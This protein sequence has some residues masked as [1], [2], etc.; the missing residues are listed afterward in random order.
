MKTASEAVTENGLSTLSTKQRNKRTRFSFRRTPALFFLLLAANAFAQDGVIV[1]NLADLAQGA[2]SSEHSI[3]LPFE[4]WHWQA[5]SIDGGQP[6]WINFSQFPCLELLQA[7]TNVSTDTEFHGVPLVSAQL[8]KNV[9]TGEVLFQSECSSDVLAT[10]AAP[11]GYQPGV[12][13]KDRGVWEMWQQ[14]T[15][16]PDCWGVP[17]GGFLPPTVKLNV[18]LADLNDYAAYDSNLEVEAEAEALL[19]EQT[20]TTS[21]MSTAIAEADGGGG[22]VFDGRQ[23]SVYDHKYS[24]PIR[25]CEHRPRHKP[26]DDNRMA[27]LHRS[28]LRAVLNGQPQ[29]E[30]T[31]DWA[32]S[33]VG[34]RG[35]DQLDG[36][37]YHQRQSPVLQ[38]CANVAPGADFDG[39][40]IPNG[41]ELQYGINPLDPADAAGIAT[42][43]GLTYWD[44]SLMGDDFQGDTCVG[45]V[46]CGCNFHQR[47]KWYGGKP[48]STFAARH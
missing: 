17:D 40:G 6:W 32:D 16:C 20:S 15:N 13:S 38:G 46:I 10:V 27:K 33:D 4:P 22:N 43:D 30:H 2:F 7:C 5:Y 31:L 34:C 11:S 3:Y 36:H 28:Y 41:W 42:A 21:G 47:W 25:H 37:D 44:L 35:F 26:V 29:Y 18:F 9:L 39:D 1:T 24:R 14:W 19:I 45:A 12:L 8:T 48:I 23:R